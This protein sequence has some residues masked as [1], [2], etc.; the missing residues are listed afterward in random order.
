MQMLINWYQALD[1]QQPA[2]CMLLAIHLKHR[3]YYA[4]R[5]PVVNQLIKE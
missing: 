4:D 1:Q 3:S 2:V 5:S